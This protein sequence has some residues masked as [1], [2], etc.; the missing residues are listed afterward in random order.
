MHVDICLISVIRWKWKIKYTHVRAEECF[1][2]VMYECIVVY[3]FH[4]P[5]DA[6]RYGQQWPGGSGVP[7][8]LYCE[9]CPHCHFISFKWFTIVYILLY[10]MIYCYCYYHNYHICTH[11]KS[12]RTITIIRAIL[13]PERSQRIINAYKNNIHIIIRMDRVNV[14]TFLQ[15]RCF[16]FFC[17]L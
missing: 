13:I 7:L 17:S 14:H 1:M 8:C 6:T 9:C 15:F 5:C 10:V 4:I 3:I 16:F 2:F 12:H 11:F